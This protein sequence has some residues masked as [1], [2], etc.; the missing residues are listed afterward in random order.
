MTL[1]TAV[2]LTVTNLNGTTLY[3]FN[4]LDDGKY[5]YIDFYTSIQACVVNKSPNYIITIT[6]RA[7]FIA[8]S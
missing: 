1:S 6:A 8:T 5:V 7:I 2:D 3:L 4:Y